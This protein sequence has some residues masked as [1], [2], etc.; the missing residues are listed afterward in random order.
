MYHCVKHYKHGDGAKL[1]LR[2]YTS[3]DYAHKHIN[4]SFI[5]PDNLCT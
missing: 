4:E 5:S 2:I 1:S 3:E